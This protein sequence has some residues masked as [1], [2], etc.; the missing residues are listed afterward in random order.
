MK[1]ANKVANKHVMA[2][3]KKGETFRL[4]SYKNASGNTSWRVEGT[5]PPGKR[6]R[7]NFKLK[8]DAIEELAA[9]EA[10]AAGAPQ[11]RRLQPTTLSAEQLS[12][13]EAAFLSI[14]G[15]RL[16]QVVEHYKALVDR[17]E[18]KALT[19]DGAMKFAESHYRSEIEE[20]SV[21]NARDRFL[22]S[23]TGLSPRTVQSYES[24]TKQ[25]LSPDPNRL[26]HA[27]GVS[28]IEQILARHTNGNTKLAHRRSYS[29]FFNWAVRHHYCLENPC[30]RLD[31]IPTEQVL[32]SILSIEEVKRLLRA[33]VEYK[34]GVMVPVVA[35]S[36]FAGLR[37]SEVE[38]L[39]P[40][41]VNGKRI[42]VTGG[43][44]R[45]KMNR[46]VPVAEN[47][48]RWLGH[49]P[50]TGVP[51]ALAYRLK[52]LREATA[53]KNWV[54]DI[55][56]H[57]SISF[58]AMRDEDEAKTAFRNGT[59]K[60]MM[61]SHYREVI[62]EAEDVK[63]FWNI[64]PE[65][66]AA[67]KIKVKLPG[68]RDTDWPSTARLKKLVWEK[69]MVHAAKDLGVSDVALKKHCVMLGIEL[70]PRGYWLRGS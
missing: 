60:A 12:D 54:Q 8:A 43:K 53:A 63:A 52:V 67:E 17:G 64:A 15:G 25:L 21:I 1:V 9:L 32:I 48:A 33:A 44:L 70:P 61:D 50:F 3:P 65:S 23:R 26:L 38:D 24:C 22:K 45:R 51:E 28:D 7:K 2:K 41:D 4:S 16:S 31:S 49:Y 20:I 5:W 68:H 69:P 59:S 10:Q 19:L 46:G 34:E 66:L 6:V 37:P 47:L 40:G 58:Q 27:L 42:R 36:L 13:A 62:D 56:R 35:I 30:D 11:Q 55:L 14:G 39:K 57:T 29:V 18:A